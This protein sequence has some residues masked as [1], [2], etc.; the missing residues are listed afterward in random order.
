M[1]DPNPTA[2]WAAEELR[3]LTH[4]PTYGTPE[5]HHLEPTD[6]RRAAALIT[7]AE[8]WRHQQKGHQP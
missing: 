4:I 7:A 8:A 5:W 1:T 2:Q 6:P 3:H